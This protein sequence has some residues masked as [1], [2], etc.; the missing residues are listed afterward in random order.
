M[1]CQSIKDRPGVVKDIGESIEDRSEPDLFA[2]FRIEGLVATSESEKLVPIRI[3]RDT[4]AAQSLLVEGVLP[5]SKETSTGE[6][7]LVRGCGMTWLEASL[8]VVHLQSG[9]VTGPVAVA[10]CP[11]LPVE[12]VDMILGNDLAGGEVFPT[13]IVVAIGSESDDNQ[14]DQSSQMPTVFLLVL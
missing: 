14:G 13:P 7:A 1:V 12:G 8:H 4:A 6:K 5:L 3:L 11:E 2:P 10:I 9:L